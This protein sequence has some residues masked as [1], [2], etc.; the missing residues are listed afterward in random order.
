MSS[1]PKHTCRCTCTAYGG[2]CDCWFDG[3]LHGQRK[4]RDAV[5]KVIRTPG[6]FAVYPANAMHVEAF[7]WVAQLVER[8]P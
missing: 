7:E 4:M 1:S 6:M 3:D 8:M 2:H 5:V